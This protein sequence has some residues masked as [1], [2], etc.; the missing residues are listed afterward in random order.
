MGLWRLHI[1]GGAVEVAYKGWG[2][3]G[4]GVRGVAVK[5]VE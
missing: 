1:R 2:C 4:G 3:E 5:G